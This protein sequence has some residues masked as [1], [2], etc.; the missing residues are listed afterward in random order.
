[1]GR[2]VIACYRP[3]PGQAEAL[4]A[5]A[6][7]HHLRLYEQ[8][9]ATRRRPIAMVARD[10]TLLEVFEWKSQRAIDEAHH[11]P[12]VLQMWSEYA[13]VC[14]YVPVGQ[15]AG[16]AELFAGFEPFPGELQRSP[17]ANVFA[18]VQVDEKLGTSGRVTEADLAGI[19]AQGYRHVIN[20]LPNENPHALQGEA[21]IVAQLG[22][23]YR[24][25]PVDFTA[26]REQDL[27][28]F[29]S[30][31]GEVS[32]DKLWVHC[33]ANLRVTAFV[34]L[35]GLQHRGWSAARARELIGEVWQPDPTWQAFLQANGL[36]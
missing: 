4:H 2:I 14:D 1:M 9:L 18:H 6:C 19:A 7:T 12:A 28:A 3:K 13:A 22:M 15:I 20:L 25:L 23:S 16:A 35:H 36:A 17:L 8:G 34:A 32:G 21:E 11:N 24:H 31:M 26:P 5:L 30:A 10:G 29:A 27:A 33:A